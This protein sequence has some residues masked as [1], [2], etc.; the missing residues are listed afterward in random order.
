MWRTG[1]LGESL[2][3]K[4][5]SVTPGTRENCAVAGSKR[6]SPCRFAPTHSV[7]SAATRTHQ[8]ALG[9]ASPGAPSRRKTS[10]APVSGSN[11]CRPSFVAI[12][13]VPSAATSMPFAPLASPLGP[14]GMVRK[15]PVSGGR[16]RPSPR[17]VPIQTEPCASR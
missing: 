2:P 12:Q 13:M 16:Q 5:A 14:R 1:T 7:P 4:R 17:F 10:T 11:L 15:A 8:N 9:N 3:P 6:K